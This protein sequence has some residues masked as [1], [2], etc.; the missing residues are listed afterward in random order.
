M[1]AHSA[2]VVDAKRVAVVAE[3]G[4]SCV[5]RPR[6]RA[7]DGY[8]TAEFTAPIIEVKWENY[9]DIKL[10]DDHGNSVV[11]QDFSVKVRVYAVLIL[12][13][14]EYALRHDVLSSISEKKNYIRIT[15]LLISS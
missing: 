5:T 9:P 1:A 3:T 6:D 12:F 13:I 14:W 4:D 7:T 8:C 2:V 15:F 10:E 11:Y